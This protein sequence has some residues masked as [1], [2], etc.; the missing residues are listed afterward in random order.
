AHSVLIKHGD[1]QV[2]RFWG[3]DP[4]REI[5]YGSDAEYEEHFRHLFTEAVR[6]CLRSDRPVWSDLSGGLDSSSIVCV[7]DQL[8]KSGKTETSLLDNVSCIRDESPSSNETKFIR[9]VEERIGRQGH[10][11]P[12]SAFPVLSPTASECSAIP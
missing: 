3:L 7:A 1:V 4:H 11:L 12:E 8:I 10:H 9:C 6:C 5:R 2:H